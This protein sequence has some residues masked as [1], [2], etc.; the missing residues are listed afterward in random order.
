MVESGE[1]GAWSATVDSTPPD[2]PWRHTEMTACTS[3]SID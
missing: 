2:E 1:G 3:E